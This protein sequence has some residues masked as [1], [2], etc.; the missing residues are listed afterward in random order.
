M[1]AH[2]FTR[3]ARSPAFL[4]PWLVKSP[5][6][7]HHMFKSWAARHVAVDAPGATGANLPGLGHT[8]AARP[9]FPL[10]PDVAFSPQVKLFRRPRI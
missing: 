6:C 7:E 10:D 9:V 2:Y 5:H 4:T 1:T 3:T 8:H